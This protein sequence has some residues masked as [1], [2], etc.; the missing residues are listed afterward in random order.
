MDN[1]REVAHETKP[2]LIVAGA[3]AY[4]RAIDFGAF[5]EAADE[6]GAVL[7]V[8]MAHFAGLVAVLRG[9]F[10][11]QSGDHALYIDPI[12]VLGDILYTQH[13]PEGSIFEK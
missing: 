12:V 8:D 1:V 11:N 2:K 13:R 6:V 3:S 4:P 5:R 9:S 7:L 10:A